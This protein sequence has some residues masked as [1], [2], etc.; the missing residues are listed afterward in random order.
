M[1]APSSRLWLLVPLAVALL[2][3]GGGTLLLRADADA[4]DPAEA[5]ALTAALDGDFAPAVPA[6]LR[7]P[8]HAATPAFYT[9]GRLLWT[10]TGRRDAAL[11]LLGRTAR[12]GIAADAPDLP[13]APEPSSGYAVALDLALTSALLR[14]GDALAGPNVDA[15]ALHGILWY[16]HRREDAP[17]AA[18][19]DALDGIAEG[20]DPAAALDA[21][22]ATLSPRQPEAKRL[23]AALARE[24]DL[25]ERPDLTLSQ[26]LGPGDAGPDVTRLRERLAFEPD[27][28]LTFGGDRFDDALADA[29]RAVQRRDSLAVTGRLDAA[30]RDVLNAR[31]PERIAALTLNLERWRWLPDD[32][33]DLHVFVNIPDFEIVLR[34]GGRDVFESVA[35]VGK[36]GWNTNVFTDSIET[37][38]FNPTWT[39][40][41]SIQ[42]ESYGR[43]KGYVVQQPGPRNPMGRVKFVYP[44]GHAI[45]IHDT[46]A[47]WGFEQPDR[48]LSHGCVRV[49]RP[50]DLATE[51]LTRRADGWDADRVAEIFRG[52]W[53]QTQTVSLSEPVPIHHVY[54]TA[55]A[56]ADGRVRTVDDVY[57]YDDR[58]AE[59]L[60]L[61][62]TPG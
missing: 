62:G 48:A 59:A 32:L 35:A 27:V 30:T 46:T 58:L 33:G 34:E 6:A 57:G 36:A 38:V 53:G 8:H 40:P 39:M 22:A 2:G 61:S 26:N 56:D 23:R 42:R 28:A 44:N 29:V 4:I 45:F 16:P 21:Y 13:L 54:L 31:S 11:A 50:Q 49:G 41:A 43:V 52:P 25:A 15:H 20:L 10:D 7:G 47:K 5:A 24:I 37:V 12:W 18:L 60:G 19:F 55:R 9:D 17:S 51:L 1:P 14:F 3:A